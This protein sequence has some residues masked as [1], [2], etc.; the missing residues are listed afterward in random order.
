MLWWFVLFLFLLT[1]SFIYCFVLSIYFFHLS[2]FCDFCV[3]SLLACVFLNIFT[4]FRYLMTHIPS[5]FFF[6]SV[7]SYC[8]FCFFPLLF[9]L[10]FFMSFWVISLLAS[11]YF[12]LLSDAWWLTFPL[13]FSSYSWAVFL[14]ALLRSLMSSSISFTDSSNITISCSIFLFFFFLISGCA[15]A[16]LFT[17]FGL[18][19]FCF[20]VHRFW[21]VL[22]IMSSFLAAFLR[23]GISSLNISS[24]VTVMFFVVFHYFAQCSSMCPCV[25][26][27]F[28]ASS[29]C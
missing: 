7:F 1:H 4:A 8:A 19:L 11:V 5:S 24:L 25:S 15:V 12:S 14:L 26:G 22:S 16:F 3:I 27:S 29:A 18:G 13:F 23:I 17:G 20:F 2:F 21:S 6:P 9:F 10:L 28:F